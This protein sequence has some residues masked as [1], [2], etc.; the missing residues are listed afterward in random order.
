MHI[1]DIFHD[2]FN[3]TEHEYYHAHEYKNANKYDI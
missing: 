2:I 3:S 1:Y